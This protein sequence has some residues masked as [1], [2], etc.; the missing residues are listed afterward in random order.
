MDT[1]DLSY[2]TD[3]VWKAYQNGAN[4]GLRP[5]DVF[6]VFADSRA[7]LWVGKCCCFDP[8]VCPTQFIEA[9]SVHP[10]LKAFNGWAMGEDPQGRMWI[11]SNTDGVHVLTA[12][13]DSI[14]TLTPGNTGG[15]ATGFL[16]STSIRA[17]AAGP[18][19]RIWLG[20]ENN[21]LQILMTGGDPTNPSAFG[22]TTVR[23]S[24]T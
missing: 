11:G 23:R 19:N 1:I 7:R 3:G 5:S 10:A 15:N 9:D 18:D 16:R 6:S 21:G 13:G 8:P 14:T 17:V 2:S 22:W 4:G 20:H 12:A 24:A